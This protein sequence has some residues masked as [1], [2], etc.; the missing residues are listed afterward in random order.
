MIYWLDVIIFCNLTL[1]CTYLPPA[2]EV[3]GKVLLSHVSV[4]I[5]G[6]RGYPI[7]LTKGYPIPGPGRGYPIQL[8]GV[9]LPGSGRYPIPGL[10]GGTP[11]QVQ[12]GGYPGV[13]PPAPPPGLDGVTPPPS[14]YSSIASTYYAAGGMP[15]AFTQEEFLV[16]LLLSWY[17]TK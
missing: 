15:L 17:W 14:G 11:S 3:R 9:P 8:V 1:L 10:D 12:A 4:H 5:S 2:Y 6:D 7:Q 16:L 13:P